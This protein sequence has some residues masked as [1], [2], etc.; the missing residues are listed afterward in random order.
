M[1]IFLLQTLIIIALPAAVFRLAGLRRV[2][3]LVVLQILFGLALGPSLLGRFSPETYSMLFAP[4]ALGPLSGIASIAVLFFGF[5]TGLHLDTATFR[6]ETRRVA[7][8]A[9]AGT[10]G[11]T[12]AGAFGGWWIAMRYPQEL[13]AGVGIAQYSAAVA[14]ATGVTALPV[15]SAILGEMKLLGTR[16][17]TLALGMAAIADASLWLLM[18]GL[19]VSIGVGGATAGSQLIA[20][21][22]V[23]PIYLAA[24]ILVVRPLTHRFIVARMEDG[25]LGEGSLAYVCA[26]TLTSCVVTEAIGLHY[27]LGAFIAGATMP[28][29]LRRPILAQLQPMTMSVLI[30]FFFVLTGLRTLIDPTSPAFLEIFLVSTGLAVAGKILCTA[31]AARWIKESWSTSLALGS[32]MQTK[33]LM[34]VVVLTIFL[35]RGI[36]SVTTFSALVLMAVVS[37][38]LAMPLT[39]RALGKGAVRAQEKPVAA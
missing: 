33:G 38:S 5:T 25:L 19:L 37:T 8:M 16:I 31:A 13:V 4:A 14:I 7:I 20:A 15:L 28:D 6:V 34:E 23:F 26:V 18:G 3:P 1:L 17:G 11:P 30:P 27:I 35:D 24:M 21:F 22:V 2:V 12:I 29:A 10:I 36:I 39:R 32:L 9:A